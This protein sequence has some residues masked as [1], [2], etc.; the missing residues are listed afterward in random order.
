M[1]FGKTLLKRRL[2][3]AESRLE[4]PFPT[5]EQVVRMS[6]PISKIEDPPSDVSLMLRAHAE[7]RCLSREVIP[8]LRQVETRDGLPDGQLGAAMAYLEV[9][10]LEARRRAVETDCARRGLAETAGDGEPP[11][12]D[13]G[14][15]YSGACR[16]YDAVKVLRAAVARR[17]QPVLSACEPRGEAAHASPLGSP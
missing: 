10:W 5:G 2:A 16:Y 15:L 1:E 13:D 11:D 6:E 14:K 3:P 9:T 17:V 7:L 4:Q 8:V 12:P